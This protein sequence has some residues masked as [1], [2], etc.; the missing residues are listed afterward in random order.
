V[1][2]T[3]L[4]EAIEEFMAY[5]KSAGFAAN[6][7]LI[8]QRGLSKFLSLVG[9]VQVRHLEARH[10]EQF[11]A[12]LM[13]N[14][15]KPNT[16]NS[17]LTSLA[18]FVKWLR[19]R[20]YLGARSDVMA[21]VRM[22]RGMVEPRQRIEVD[23]FEALLD[24]CE[25]AHE[26][27]VCALGLYLFLRA[28]EIAGIRLRDVNLDRG[29]VTIHVMKTKVVDVMP[30]SYELDRELRRWLTWYAQD[31]EGPLKSD[32]WLVP[33]RRRPPMAN[34]G[35]GP[36]GGYMVRRERGNC[37]PMVKGKRMHRY[38]QRALE[39]FGMDLRGEDGKSLMEGC[40]TLRR[41]GARA[42]FDDLVERGGYDGVLRHVSAILHHSSTLM[43]ERYLGLDVDVKK[44][45]DLIRG[46]K[47]YRTQRDVVEDSPNITAIGVES[48]I[49]NE[50]DRGLRYV[51]GA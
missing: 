5:R 12:A 33:S 25:T 16:V 31:I 9:N 19:S 26:R 38:V 14:G 32:Y 42:L 30:I 1:S 6:T 40:H 24:S 21:N 15:Y 50:A 48:G 39:N 28:S 49:S 20:R 37:L 45:N 22:V 7:L 3:T 18:A 51:P 29:E 4:S 23:D 11:Q 17:Y 44:R 46:K 8:N 36:G 35:S 47:M 27:I 41:S 13:A 43:T 10:G 2:T 34:D